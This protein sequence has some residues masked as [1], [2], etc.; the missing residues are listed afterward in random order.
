MK[1]VKQWLDRM[2]KLE[3]EPVG[4]TKARSMTTDTLKSMWDAFDGNANDGEAGYFWPN[5]EPQMENEHGN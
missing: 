1:I 3:S 2:P 4:L 5:S